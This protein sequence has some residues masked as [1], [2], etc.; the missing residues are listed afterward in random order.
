MPLDPNHS[1]HAEP[2]FGGDSV[3]GVVQPPNQ[4]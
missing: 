4:I 1:H 3:D 2:H